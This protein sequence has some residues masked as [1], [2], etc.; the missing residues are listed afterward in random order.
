MKLRLRL[1]QDSIDRE[2]NDKRR[3]EYPPLADLADAIYWREKGDPKPMAD[4]VAKVDAIK[5]KHPKQK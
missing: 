1:S 5:A 4:Y 3:A 2:R